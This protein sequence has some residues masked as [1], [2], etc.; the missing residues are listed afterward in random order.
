[1]IDN[2]FFKYLSIRNIFNYQMLFICFFYNKFNQFLS[3]KISFTTN[4]KAKKPKRGNMNEHPNRTQ[5]WSFSRRS[6][7]SFSK[8]ISTSSTAQERSLIDYLQG[9]SRIFYQRCK[10]RNK[11]CIGIKYTSN[12]AASSLSFFYVI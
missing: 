7:L 12:Y 9:G 5:Q 4:R 2:W 6:L 1:M 3:L 8:H 10:I 11:V